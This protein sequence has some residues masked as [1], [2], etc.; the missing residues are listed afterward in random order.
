MQTKSSVKI[1]LQYVNVDKLT[2]IIK[3]IEG[4]ITVERLKGCNRSIY[5]FIEVN[6]LKLTDANQI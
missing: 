6:F 3:I 4:P 5:N 2:S 1:W